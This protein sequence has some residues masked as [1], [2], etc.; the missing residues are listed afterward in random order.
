VERKERFTLRR[1]HNVLNPLSATNTQ[2]GLLIIFIVR[3]IQAKQTPI[4]LSTQ[5]DKRIGTKVLYMIKRE[6]DGH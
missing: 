3:A 6:E 2:E 5:R 1:V 4:G